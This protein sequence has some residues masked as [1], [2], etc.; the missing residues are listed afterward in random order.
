MTSSIIVMLYRLTK[1]K[2]LGY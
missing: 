2:E 1:F